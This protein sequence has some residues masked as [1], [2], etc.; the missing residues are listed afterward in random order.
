MHETVC[1][2][3]AILHGLCVRHQCVCAALRKA[4]VACVAHM[5]HTLQVLKAWKDDQGVEGGD[6]LRKRVFG[7][8][9]SAVVLAS[10][11]LAIDIIASYSANQTAAA[12]GFSGV[13]G[14]QIG[15]ILLQTLSIYFAINAGVLDMP[16]AFVRCVTGTEWIL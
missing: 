10:V 14:S 9:V 4:C 6:D 13:T 8:G 5:T 11:Q 2:H 16:A 3:V 15:A 7:I 12:V 1:L